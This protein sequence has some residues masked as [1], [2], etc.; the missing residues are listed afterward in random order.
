LLKLKGQK[1]QVNDEALEILLWIDKALVNE[2]T[3]GVN[4]SGVG[5]FTMIGSR[6]ADTSALMNKLINE[7]NGVSVIKLTSLFSSKIVIYMVTT[8]AKKSRRPKKVSK[9]GAIP[10]YLNKGASSPFR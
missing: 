5:V 10:S 7:E 2:S 4:T 3:E 8:E 1:I 9:C 6:E